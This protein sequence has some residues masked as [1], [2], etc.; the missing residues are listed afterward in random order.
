MADV[1]LRDLQLYM[2]DILKEIDRICKKYDIQYFLAYGSCLGAVRHKGFIPWD[3]D[4][5]LHMKSDDF[6]KFMEVCKTELGDKYY[7]ES[8]FNNVQSYQ[9]WNQFGVKNST[10]INMSMSHVHRA[11]GIC[12]DIFPIFPYSKESNVQKKRRK[13]FSL[14]KLLSLKYYHVGTLQQARGVDKIKKMIHYFLPDNINLKLFRYCFRKLCEPVENQQ[15][16][17]LSS[18]SLYMSPKEWFENEWFDDIIRM[19]YEGE[20]FPCPI[21]YEKYLKSLYGDYMQI[22]KNKI[23]H[24]DDPNVVVKFDECYETY[25]S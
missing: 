1:E 6:L 11:W 18:Y 21:G 5:D 14:M 3:D 20:K 16:S 19:E 9:F 7:L 25:W 17:C 22:P 10:S 12:V 8:H 13:I 23:K 15:E 4:I 2:L 24:S